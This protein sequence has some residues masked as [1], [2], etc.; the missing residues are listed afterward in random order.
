M[1]VSLYARVSKSSS[2]QDTERQI[3][4]LRKYCEI[5]GFTI[6]EEITENITGKKVKRAGILKLINLA[7]QKKIN[8]VIIHEVSRLGRNMADVVN[9]VEELKKYKVSVIDYNQKQET[10]DENNNY[11]IFGQIIFPLLSGLAAREVEQSSYRIKSGLNLA[12]SKGIKLGRPKKEKIK[13]EEDISKL[14]KSGIIE[15]DIGKIIKA[16][17]RNIAKYLGVSVGTV[18][19]V[20][21]GEKLN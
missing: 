14:L 7:K 10:L 5:E 3:N 9:T 1:N 16:S 13:K 18:K 17:N 20:R 2:L 4:E 15:T 21:G 19:K 12:R 8:K 11:T 6:I